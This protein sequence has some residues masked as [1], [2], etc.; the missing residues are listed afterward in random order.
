MPLRESKTP[1]AQSEASQR[2]SRMHSSVRKSRSISANL[3]TP[4][5][6]RSSHIRAK[7]RCTSLSAKKPGMKPPISSLGSPAANGQALNVQPIP[8]RRPRHCRC[9]SLRRHRGSAAGRLKPP[10]GGN[11]KPI[12]SNPNH[13]RD[14]YEVGERRPP[15]RWSSHFYPE[16]APSSGASGP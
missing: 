2:A 13:Y 4:Q 3:R 16:T 14:A 7:G 12:G 15:S 6:L 10:N 1:R 5:S 11:R 8:R 9:K